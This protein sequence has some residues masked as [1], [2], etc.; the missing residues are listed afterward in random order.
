M[1]K[2][3]S[4]IIAAVL[5]LTFTAGCNSKNDSPAQ[6]VQQSSGPGS[7]KTD[8]TTD[9]YS[10]KM[11]IDWAS[12]MVNEGTDYNADEFSQQWCEKCFQTIW[13]FT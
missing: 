2:T 10:K 1:R 13:E 9:K 11:V 7:A 12:V 8:T 5:L 6:P 4:F 3:V